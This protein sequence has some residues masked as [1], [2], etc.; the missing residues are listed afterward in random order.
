MQ[1]AGKQVQVSASIRAIARQARQAALSEVTVR[2]TRQP[3]TQEVAPLVP[4]VVRIP[5][6]PPL[7]FI[8]DAAD[9][10]GWFT[11][12]FIGG[13]A[14]LRELKDRLIIRVDMQDEEDGFGV[15][16]TEFVPSLDASAE[17]LMG[18]KRMIG[19][20]WMKVVNAFVYNPYMR[21]IQKMD[22]KVK[23]CRACKYTTKICCRYAINELYRLTIY[24][25][26][27]L[28]FLQTL[29]CTCGLEITQNTMDMALTLRDHSVRW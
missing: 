10:D 13:Y 23:R 12:I 14:S 9:K 20:K 18:Q 16:C 19:G 17:H 21:R 1:K 26:H 22:S 5:T 11:D 8:D 24:I 7:E 4:P 29:Q 2:R 6:P 15:D 27:K 28:E 25:F 3:R